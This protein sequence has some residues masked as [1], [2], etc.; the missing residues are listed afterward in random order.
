MRGPTPED[1]VARN[2]TAEFGQRIAVARREV[3]LTQRE[4]ADRIGVM[5]GVLEAYETGLAD[6]SPHLDRI[7]EA[8]G[9]EA[10]WFLHG[11][12]PE[13]VVARLQ[14]NA[15]ELARREAALRRQEEELALAGKRVEDRTRG[16]QENLLAGRELEVKQ[17]QAE[18]QGWAR[19]AARVA[20]EL[21]YALASFER[22]KHGAGPDAVGTRFG[23]EDEWAEF[24]SARAEAAEREAALVARERRLAAR[25]EA[26]SR[27]E[28]ELE[29]KL[30]EAL[31]RAREHEQRW[32]R[33]AEA[34]EELRRVETDLQGREGSLS[35]AEAELAERVQALEERGAELARQQQ[36]LEE[37]TAAAE[38]RL[39]GVREGVQQTMAQLEAQLAQRDL[40]AGAGA[41]G[42][43]RS[44]RRR[45]RRQST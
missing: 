19:V 25:E 34:F 40:K 4:L 35:R 45:L 29:Q 38:H 20:T 22:V 16:Q 14:R 12:D 30:E 39:A 24:E 32:Q 43:R 17:R 8:T 28:Q 27:L 2:E 21:R 44:L 37:A 5:L 3:G 1:D 36:D 10:L 6:P 41:D 26:C 18:L 15:A 42:R 7:A 31:E 9:K 13:E 11:D 33:E 23:E